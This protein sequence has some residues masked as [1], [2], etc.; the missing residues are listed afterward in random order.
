M[1]IVI[2]QEDKLPHLVGYVFSGMK[3]PGGTLVP[4]EHL[5]R[6]AVG[7]LRL[8]LTEG[9]I[10]R[11]ITE[12]AAEPVDAKTKVRLDLGDVDDDPWKLNSGDIVKFVMGQED[13]CPMQ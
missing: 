12:A 9:D 1:A 11:C 4:Q 10:G 7:E 2:L 3:T 13:K 5:W 6:M 8:R